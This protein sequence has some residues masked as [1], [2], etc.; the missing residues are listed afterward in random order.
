MIIRLLGVVVF[1]NVNVSGQPEPDTTFNGTGSFPGGLNFTFVPRDVKV[2]PDKKTVVLSPCQSPLNLTMYEFCF[3]RLNEDGTTDKTFND[4]IGNISPPGTSFVLIPGSSPFDPGGAGTGLVVLD[5]GKIFAVGSATLSNVQRPVMIRLNPDGTLDASFGTNGV[6]VSPAGTYFSKAALQ[7]DGKVVV[8]GYSNPNPMI[9]RF[10]PDGTPDKTFGDN[11]YK[12]LTH[13]DGNSSSYSI[14]LQADGKILTGGS[15]SSTSNFY[16]LTRLNPDGS[17]DTNFGN[18]GFLNINAGQLGWD[19]ADVL[20]YDR[21]GRLF[22][23]GRTWS[24]SGDAP[25]QY[26][27]FC[28]AR[29][30]ASPAQN[31]GFSGRVT[32][33][34]AKAVFNAVITLKDGSESV[35]L[36]RANPFGY[37]SFKNIPNNRTYKLSTSAKNLNFYDREVL[38]DDQ[39]TDFLVVGRC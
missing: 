14:A 32:D 25:W 11:G 28:A 10:F 33:T 39:V 26:S 3:I 4:E 35:A 22:I 27:N 9:A 5:D 8:T 19:G 31:V 34:D 7:P 1:F 36:A 17:P 37:F 29:L 18:S 2:Q 24:G 12:I 30:I 6:I 20:I 23:G 16:L 21:L 38:L 13:P 15:L